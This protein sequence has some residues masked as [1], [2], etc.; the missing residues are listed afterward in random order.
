MSERRS[1][2]RQDAPFVKDAGKRFL[3]ALG[4]TLQLGM[5][6]AGLWLAAWLV[7]RYAPAARTPWHW[8]LLILGAT[9]LFNYGYLLALLALRMIIPRPKE[10]AYTIV[11]GKPVPGQILLFML[12]ALLA[13]FRY[14]PPWA[15]TF[16]A[17]LVSIFPLRPLFTRFFGPRTSSMTLGDTVVYLDPHMVEIGK[18]VQLGFQ[19]TIAAHIFNDRKM[20]IRKVVIGD[21]AV[22]GGQAGLGAGVQIGHHAI[23]DRRAHVQPFSVVGPY[24]FWSG[25]PA[26]KIKTLRPAEELKAG[27]E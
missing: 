3:L 2:T 9:L 17:V 13:K 19:C 15:A 24:E 23:I 11:P 4:F 16:S 14:E 25:D 12:N 22:I 1:E 7:L 18:N 8:V 20:I 5:M 27:Q 6:A 21:H 26:R 10:G